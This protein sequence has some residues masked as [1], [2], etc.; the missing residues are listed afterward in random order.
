MI[1]MPAGGAPIA[2]QAQDPITWEH[3]AGNVWRIDGA[4]DVIIAQAGKDGLLMV[5]TGYPAAEDGVRSALRK[6]AG[7]DRPDRIVN[8]HIHHGFSNHLYG[9]E[10][11]IVAHENVSRRMESGFLM[12]G[13]LVPPFLDSAR[14]DIVFRDSL[15]FRM[16]GEEISLIHVPNAH[17]DSDVVVIFHGSN[18]VA[19]G[20]VLVPHMPWISLNEGAD[21]EGLL[22]ALDRLLTIVPENA[23][24]IPGHDPITLDK[25]DLGAFRAMIAQAADTVQARMRAGMGLRQIQ[26]LGLPHLAAWRGAVPEELFIESLYRSFIRA[27]RTPDAP[28]LELVN[29]LWW[30]GVEFVP[31]S[32]Y[33]IDGVLTTERPPGIDRTIDLR[34]G[35]T[36]PPFGEAHT[37]RL[38]DPAQL[39]ED[40]ASFLSDGIFYAMV[41]D[42]SV[43]LGA[44]HR[45][46]ASEADRPE[47]AYTQGVVT[48]SR[49]V[50]ADFYGMRAE[51]GFFGAGVTLDD[52]DGKVLFRI[53]S[54]EDL[55]A[56][57]PSLKALNDRFVKVIVAFS[58][59]VEKRLADPSAY[60]ADPPHY[61]AKPGVT[62]EVLE[63]LI[64][65]AHAAGLQVSAH[66]ETAADFRLVVE[67]GVDW[68]AHMPASWQVGEGSGYGA[69][70]LDPWLL[71]RD[72]AMAARRSRAITVTTLAPW[73]E[74]DSR[75]EMFRTVHSQNL[76]VLTEAGAPLA[77]GSDLFEGS[78][79]DEVL[80]LRTL[81]ALSDAQL[82]RLLAV[83]TPRSIF[84]DRRIGHLTDG[85]EASFLVLG[86]DPTRDLATIRDIRLRVKRG[87]VLP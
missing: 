53:D 64:T 44:S 31:R 69:D 61:S 72:D 80:Y 23:R 66:I 27:R 52:L 35:Y 41:Q 20:D 13:V 47:V 2:A 10:A 73:S 78:V 83:Q 48:P 37:H 84:P 74:D 14:P 54:V 60:V 76:R 43:E 8:T 51:A 75:E 82:F 70:D 81:G 21:A 79:V 7:K 11:E 68:V 62:A 71:T 5:D 85:Y 28:T 58:D 16:N 77:I 18:V 57:W 46:L 63:S 3:V 19:T 32:M 25:S 12:A 40:A 15:R 38:S 33:A 42:P 86:G 24:I 26:T 87:H 39:N 55:N 34:G 59:E 17:T 49:G 30:D 56:A 50:I 36:V 4:I 45:E 9:V 29:G 6:I 65:W 67:A 1:L 22:A